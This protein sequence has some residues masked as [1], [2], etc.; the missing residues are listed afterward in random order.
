VKRLAGWGARVLRFFGGLAE[1]F[2][3]IAIVLTTSGESGAG[4]G[5]WTETRLG[6]W[7]GVRGWYR[8]TLL[9]APFLGPVF[10]A[11]VP[12]PSLPTW[13][14]IFVGALVALA[15]FG[16]ITAIF[17]LILV[18]VIRASQAPR[19]WADVVIGACMVGLLSGVLLD[20]APTTPAGWLRLYQWMFGA[21]WGWLYWFF[22]RRPKPPYAT[23]V[24]ADDGVALPKEPSAP[25]R[26]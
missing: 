13:M 1:F 23:R 8:S 2:A 20:A 16:G 22:A 5:F 25:H 19:P 4:Y 17:W 14:T 12:N 7:R 18:G 21:V 9:A 10:V 3:Y 11:A 15:I 26:T 6:A 24:E